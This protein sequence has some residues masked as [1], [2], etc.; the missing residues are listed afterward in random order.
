[1]TDEELLGYFEAGQAPPG[2]FHHAEHVRVAWCYA[3]RHPWVAAL[4]RFRTSLKGFAEAQGKPTLYH[5]TITTAFMALVAERLDAGGSGADWETFAARNADLLS[6]KPSILDRYYRP[7]TLA[8]ERARRMF[9]L[10]DAR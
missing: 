7:E 6:W 10:P 1:M 4:E 3:R 9:V 8:S 2:G 5:E